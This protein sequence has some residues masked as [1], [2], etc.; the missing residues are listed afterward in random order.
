MAKKVFSIPYAYEMYGRVCVEAD[1]V[2]EAFEKAEGK[3]KGMGWDELA[4]YASPLADSLE[5]DHEGIVLDEDGNP[6]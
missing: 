4:A 3:V 1:T 2:E 6:I 5:V